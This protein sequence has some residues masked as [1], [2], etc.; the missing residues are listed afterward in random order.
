MTTHNDF[1]ICVFRNLRSAALPRRRR[2]RF[3]FIKRET[4]SV[5]SV[6]P[7]AIFHSIPSIR[8]PAKRRIRPKGGS[9]LVIA[10]SRGNGLT[11][12]VISCPAGQIPLLRPNKMDVVVVVVVAFLLVGFF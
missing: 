3:C 1:L 11:V 8:F 6:A 7:S 5:W 2:R 10:A 12:D 4:N 9:E